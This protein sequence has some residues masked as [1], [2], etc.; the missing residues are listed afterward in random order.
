MKLSVALF[1]LL[2][3]LL[4]CTAGRK[5][6]S[7]S[8]VDAPVDL[9]GTLRGRTTCVGA[10]E[11]TVGRGV[12]KTAF[13]FDM[14]WAKDSVFGFTVYTPLGN[15]AVSIEAEGDSCRCQTERSTLV[16]GRSERI[17]IPDVSLSLPV[18]CTDLIYI[19]T[20]DP[21]ILPER[22]DSLF[23][24]GSVYCMSGRH[25]SWNVRWYAGKKDGQ[26]S[27]IVFA[28]PQQPRETVR[29]SRFINRRAHRIR[30]DLSDGSFCEVAFDRFTEQ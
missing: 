12:Q 15:E 24:A 20:M 17:S 8:T 29:F 14:Q 11:L 22:A 10:G 3:F 1:C 21:A 19:L 9:F 25:D 6:I 13:S 26:I 5:A 27:E 16:L 28:N 2:T 23:D 18:S 4:S 7:L 30:F